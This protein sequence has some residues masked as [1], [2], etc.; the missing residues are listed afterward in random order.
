MSGEF[1]Q[2][3]VDALLAAAMA[4]Q[5][6]EVIKNAEALRRHAELTEASDLGG[7]LPRFP[8]ARDREAF[9]ALDEAIAAFT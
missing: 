3:K 1:Y 6:R 9:K 8:D 7:T 4:V 5:Q 2:A